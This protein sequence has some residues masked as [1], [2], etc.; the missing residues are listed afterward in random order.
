MIH[1]ERGAI[2]TGNTRAPCV[3]TSERLADMLKFD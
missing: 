2:T 3:I 1:A